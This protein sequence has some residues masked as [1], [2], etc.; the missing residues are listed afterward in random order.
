MVLGQAALDDRGLADI[1][2]D[3]AVVAWD[4]DGLVRGYP[5]TSGVGDL[6]AHAC[7]LHAVLGARL[8]AE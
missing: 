7:R 4:V 8:V 2:L 5:F 1:Q 3:L 6:A